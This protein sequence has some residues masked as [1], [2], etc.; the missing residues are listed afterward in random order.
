MLR[1]IL[2]PSM[3][4]AVSMVQA[5]DYTYE[6][7]W[8][9]QNRPLDGVMRAEVTV[10][11]LAPIPA[12]QVWNGR[13]YGTWQGVDFD[14][15]VKFVGEASNLTGTALIDGASYNWRAKIDHK[16]FIGTFDGSRYN[17]RFSL[18]RLP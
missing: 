15:T 14:Y 13:F 17:G 9:T 11:R 12:Q 18:Q 6:G 5:A 1:A 7:K 16:T 2:W 8:V 3:M 4:M 10:D